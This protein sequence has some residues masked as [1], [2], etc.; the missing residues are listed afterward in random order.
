MAGGMWAKAGLAALLGS[1]MLA[2]AA[3]AE[4]RRVALLIGNEAYPADVGVLENPHEDV[5]AVAAALTKAGFEPED[6]IV[7]KDADQAGILQGVADMTARLREAQGEGVG[8]FYFSGHGGSTQSAGVRENYL[9]PVGADIASGDQLPLLGVPLDGVIKTLHA[10]EA[11]ANFIVIDACRNTLPVEGSKALGGPAGDKGFAPVPTRQGLY[12]AYATSDGATAPDDGAFGS[13]LAAQ[14]TVPGQYADRMFELVRR[15]VAATRGGQNLPLLNPGLTEDFCFVSCP[16]EPPAPAAGEKTATTIEWRMWDEAVTADT[17]EAYLEFAEAFPAGKFAEQA[18]SLAVR[19]PTAEERAAA[20]SAP[21]GDAGAEAVERMV[22]AIEQLAAGLEGVARLGGIID[23]PESIADF[24]NNA[25]VYER[26]GDLLNARKMYER[27]IAQNVEA[28][29]VHEKYAAILK[30]Q[31]GLLGAREIYADLAATHPANPTVLLAAAKLGPQPEREDKLEAI[32]AD[33]PVFGPVHYEM[34]LMLGFEEAGMLTPAEAQRL[35]E[36]AQA[37]MAAD[38]QG[39]I[40]RWYIDRSVLE[41]IRSRMR[42]D[43]ARA[44]SFA[45]AFGQTLV[46]LEPTLWYGKWNLRISL[47]GGANDVYVKMPG[48]DD[49]ELQDV[50]GRVNGLIY[51]LDMSL[52]GDTEPFYFEVKFDDEKGESQGPFELFFDPEPHYI[53]VNKEILLRDR[54]QWVISY[55]VD[56]SEYDQPDIYFIDM[57]FPFDYHC[58]ITKFEYGLDTETPDIEIPV[59]ECTTDNYRR[60]DDDPE[61]SA[62]ELSESVDL[63]SVRVTFTDGEERLELFDLSNKW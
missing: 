54:A 49:F 31:E 58:S 18:K 17:R 50:F 56:R 12:I 29:D 24:L 46:K 62:L 40:E 20:R 43:L 27:A 35:G 32:A 33:F 36:R 42:I 14:I 23:Q 59:P 45:K 9:V 15:E 26:R 41:A 30:A 61:G 48:H 3:W 34:A 13:S 10:V 39:H 21:G 8:F 11:K 6:I 5:D 16:D 2:G 22:G 60:L 38:T 1:T 57:S 53:G 63:V 7:V 28:V 19:R 52:P 55:L 37:F 51:T 4:E 47:A 25:D 44:E